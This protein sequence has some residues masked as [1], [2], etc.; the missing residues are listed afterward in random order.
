MGRLIERIPRGSSEGLVSGKGL[1]LH[2]I[3]QDTGVA[4]WAKRR[5]FWFVGQRR[6]GPVVMT[7]RTA[8]QNPGEKENGEEAAGEMMNLDVY[9]I[10][11]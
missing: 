10:K 4:D 8:S 2:L 11:T 5:T 6:V 7:K 1:T 9:I 3:P